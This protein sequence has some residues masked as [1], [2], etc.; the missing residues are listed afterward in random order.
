MDKGR[1]DL[2]RSAWSAAIH[3]TVLEM[4]LRGPCTDLIVAGLRAAGRAAVP[5]ARLDVAAF[6]T[7]P[8]MVA[9]GAVFVRRARRAG[10]TARDLGYDGGGGRI[11]AGA[12]TGAAV[13]MTAVLAGIVDVSLFDR[14]A[15]AEPSIARLRTAGAGVWIA[16]LIGNGVAVPLSEEFAWRGYIQ[17]RLQTAWGAAPAVVVCAALFAAKHVAVDRSVLRLVTL[18]TGAVALGIVRARYGTTASSLAHVVLNLAGTAASIAVS[19][20]TAPP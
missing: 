14:P 8:I 2:V 7:T 5:A 11:A 9:L 12:L 6:L 15:V 19:I 16:L 4:A 3:W 13:L 10:M 20:L 18:A 17:T 1:A